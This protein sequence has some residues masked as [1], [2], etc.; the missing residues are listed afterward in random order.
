MTTYRI[1]ELAR[2]AD[3]TVDTIRYYQREG[4]LHRGE[5][6][7]RFARY[8]ESHLDRLRQIRTLQ[9][10]R[11]SLAAIAAL[12]D[13]QTI[14]VFTDPGTA[15]YSAEELAGASGLT[16][17]FLDRLIAVGSLADPRTI[18]QEAFDEA[19]LAAARAF[20]DLLALGMPEDALVELSGL[21]AQRF[22]ALQG[23][24]ME[25]FAM[26]HESRWGADTRDR[27]LEQMPRHRGQLSQDVRNIITYAHERGMQRYVFSLLREGAEHDAEAPTP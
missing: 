7:G 11:F 12:L 2:V 17:G 22:L 27:F 14:G 26:A 16:P 5:R 3:V 21:Y 9:G 6:C 10:R 20:A 18:G 24:L 8:D 13:E 19:D 1:D 15:R 23:E 25:R 4:L